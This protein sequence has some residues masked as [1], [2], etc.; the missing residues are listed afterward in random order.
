MPITPAVLIH[1]RV[2]VCHLDRAQWLKVVRIEE[3]HTLLVEAE[4]CR[5]NSQHPD[6]L[7]SRVSISVCARDYHHMLLHFLETTTKS[8]HMEDF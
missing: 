6:V 3:R 1:A 2:S 7:K 5:A 8:M 4:S